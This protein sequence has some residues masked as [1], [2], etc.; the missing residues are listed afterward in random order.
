MGEDIPSELLMNGI[1]AEYPSGMMH[2][3]TLIYNK[4]TDSLI[5][6][7]GAVIN[8]NYTAFPRIRIELWGLIK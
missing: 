8:H 7:N 6:V 1:S 4:L 3:T 2:H 5:V